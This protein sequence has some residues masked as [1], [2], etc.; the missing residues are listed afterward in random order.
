M[1]D[2]SV[3]LPIRCVSVSDLR[4]SIVK[5][6]WLP[7]HIY[8]IWCNNHL[9]SDYID[10]L[11]IVSTISYNQYHKNQS[12]SYLA[13]SPIFFPA[14]FHVQS[15]ESTPEIRLSARRLRVIHMREL[16]RI[17]DEVTR[18]FASI[19]SRLHGWLTLRTPILALLDLIMQPV[20]AKSKQSSDAWVRTLWRK[21]V[22][23]VWQL[24]D[25]QLDS[26]YICRL[27]PRKQVGKLSIIYTMQNAAH[28][29]RSISAAAGRSYQICAGA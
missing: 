21:R 16:A 13:P 2:T 14:W 25:V 20:A 28:V 3:W 10:I 12:F 5:S 6:H 29:T 19:L 8:N 9:I 24:S 15:R 22:D 26:A 4:R 11:H 18:Q 17:G 23:V 27:K 7:Y 1:H